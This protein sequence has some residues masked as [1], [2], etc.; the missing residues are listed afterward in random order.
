MWSLYNWIYG[1]Q[2]INT[3][4][5]PPLSEMNF[6]TPDGTYFM[7][8]PGRNLPPLKDLLTKAKLN[9]KSPIIVDKLNDLSQLT[10]VML[11][12]NKLKKVIIQPRQTEWPCTNPLFNELRAKVSLV[13]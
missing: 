12:R 13:N 10:E 5:P 4:T 3:P 7:S 11:I 9:L 6:K 1:E 2:N 8:G